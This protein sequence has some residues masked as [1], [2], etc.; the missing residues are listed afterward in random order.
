MTIRIGQLA[1][2]ALVA[3]AAACSSTSSSSSNAPASTQVLRGSVALDA[4]A[5]DNPVVV[6]RT[7]DGRSFFAPIHADG[8]FAVTVPSGTPIRLSLANTTRSGGYV[9]ISR[10]F[11]PGTKAVWARL[12]GAAPISLGHV[13]PV[14]GGSLTA[15]DHGGGDYGDGGSSSG[16]DHDGSG[17]EA[18]EGNEGCGK[19]HAC[20]TTAPGR[21]DLPYDVRLPVGAPF[22]LD[23]A[24]LA[25]G[26]APAAI[27]K[28]TMDGGTWR[29]AELQVDESFVVTQADCTHAGNRDVGRDRIVVTWKNADGSTASDH[30]DL[31][32]CDGSG[33]LATQDHGGSYGGGSDG[34][35]DGMEPNDC[36]SD[37]TRVCSSHDERD[38][39]C[40]GHA[41]GAHVEDG[42]DHDEDDA[43]CPAD[44][45]AP[46][47]PTDAGAGDAAGDAAGGGTGGGGTGAGGLGDPCVV[48]ADCGSNLFCIASQC[49]VPIK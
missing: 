21:S 5:V 19:I 10:V 3:S 34:D 26:P 23:Q 45:G 36:E 38:S 33:G 24:F 22:R 44:G 41:D 11:W 25:K 1:L 16:D 42:D 30:L 31:R 46:P 32:Y 40:D 48:N 15:Q 7:A 47:P 14:A 28:V 12:D 37:G 20:G 8:T 49:G 17:G 39:E 18:S 6:A 35:D 9:A 4:Y 13:R 27:L 2:L 29:L 43:T